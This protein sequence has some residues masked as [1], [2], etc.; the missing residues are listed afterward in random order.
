MTPHLPAIMGLTAQELEALQ[1]DAKVACERLAN[2]EAIEALTD[3]QATAYLVS[4][5]AQLAVIVT[6]MHR[7]RALRM[8]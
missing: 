8:S 2:G 6:E 3:D 4:S 7:R 1:R 5:E